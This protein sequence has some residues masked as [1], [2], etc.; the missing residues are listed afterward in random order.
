[1]L[2]NNERLNKFLEL[3]KSELS[4]NE[5]SNN[6]D[7]KPGTLRAFL[8]KNGYKSVKG[9]YVNEENDINKES[10]ESKLP[11]GNKAGKEK[12][13]NESGTEQLNFIEAIG[14]LESDTKSMDN[15]R[16]TKNI[17]EKSGKKNK[18]ETKEKVKKDV[19]KQKRKV[20]KTT[21]KINIT[22]EDMDKLCE[23]YDW[24][25]QVKD[26]ISAEI[27]T[28]DER[29][30]IIVETVKLKD[31]KSTT[32]RVDSNTWSEFERLCSNSKFSKPVVLTQALKDFM[33][34][35]KNIL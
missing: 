3:Q 23:V 29:D 34:N 13:V 12:K 1:M 10:Q 2:D 35:Y 5:I 6:M 18:N 17:K 30:D 7:I 26:K 27:Q 31:V 33:K 24:Y 16:K 19:P 28:N 21:K 25:L 8:N 11:K 4:F 15:A 20:V 22:P 14:K 32:I 9:E